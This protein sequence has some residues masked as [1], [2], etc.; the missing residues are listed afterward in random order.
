VLIDGN[1]DFVGEV[2][3]AERVTKIVRGD[4][5]CLSISTAS[6]LA[7][8]TRDRMMR[9]ADEHYP[10]YNFAE[11]KGYPCPRHKLALT[12]YGP[13]TLHRRSWVFM[14]HI[15]WAVERIVPIGD[16]LSLFRDDSAVSMSGTGV[17]LAG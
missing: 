15:P 1:W 2:V 10:G 14:E 3:G 11:N 9:E 17:P 7:K 4:A 8:V 16:Q 5:T 6:V 12:A 13:T